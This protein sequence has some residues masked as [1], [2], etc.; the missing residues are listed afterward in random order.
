MDS[1][2]QA[3]VLNAKRDALEAQLP[4]VGEAERMLIRQQIVEFSREIRMYT[5]QVEPSPDTRS[6]MVRL[7]DRWRADPLG[8]TV[9]SLAVGSIVFSVWLG[10]ASCYMPWRHR[11][12]PY[13]QKQINRRHLLG[14]QLKSS[15]IPPIAKTAFTAG[16]LVY[17]LRQIEERISDAESRME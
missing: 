6:L 1:L 7:S 4:D 5:S 15:K 2:A 11:V 10:A 12:A 16:M 13:T 17:L 3:Q 8:S 14:F 9:T